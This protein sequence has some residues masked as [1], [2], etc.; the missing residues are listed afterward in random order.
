MATIL[1]DL[2]GTLL[3]RP[4]AAWQDRPTPKRAALNAALSELTGG[5]AVDY[6][7]GI[8]DGLTDWL[9]C[10][11]ALRTAA[12]DA[13][14][15][16]DAW[17]QVVARAEALLAPPPAGSSPVYAPL[18]GVPGVL[19]ALRAA[20]HTLGLATGNIAVFALHKLAQAGIDRGLLRDL[21][22]VIGD[23]QE[24]GGWVV[25]S[26]LKQMANWI[27]IGAIVM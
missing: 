26:F 1:C 27:W 23:R 2:D 25:R 10:E 24:D 13:V 8:E 16:A 19:D 17:R 4:A 21:Y 7:H 14:L 11:R 6:R 18:P 5:R 20:G 12:P 3:R 15:D 22:I 9:I